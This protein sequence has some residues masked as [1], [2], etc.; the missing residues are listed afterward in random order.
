MHYIPVVLNRRS[1]GQIQPT[2]CLFVAPELL[3]LYYVF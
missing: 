2:S 1:P 3:F